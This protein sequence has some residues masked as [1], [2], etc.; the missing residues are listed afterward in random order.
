V[1][2]RLT[3]SRDCAQAHY[4]IR[5]REY[6]PA[7]RSSVDTPVWRAMEQA[8]STLYPGCSFVRPILPGCTDSRFYRLSGA[9]AY[10]TN[11]FEPSLDFTQL[12][13]CFHGDNERISLASLWASTQYFALIVLNAMADKA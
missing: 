3:L 4:K 2:G 8:A 6:T 7:T 1:A 5:R 9:V 11:L 12:M 13:K 10:G